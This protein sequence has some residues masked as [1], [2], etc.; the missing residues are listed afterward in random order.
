MYSHQATSLQLNRTWLLQVEDNESG[1]L[2][3][4]LAISRWIA[5]SHGGPWRRG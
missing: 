3:I 2:G 5:L 4:G 1:G